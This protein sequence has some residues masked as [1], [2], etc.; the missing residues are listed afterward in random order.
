V[1]VLNAQ[2]ITAQNSNTPAAKATTTKSINALTPQAAMTHN[3]HTLSTP[4]L[5]NS[6]K[7]DYR[8]SNTAIVFDVDDVI[9]KRTIPIFSLAWQYKVEI[10]KA[11]FNFSLLKDVFTLIR[12]TAPVGVYISLFERKQP[13]LVPFARELITTRITDP[14][15][16]AIIKT[17]LSLGYELHIGT[18]E[19]ANEFLLH[20]ERFPIFSRFATYTFADYSTFPDVTQKPQLRYFERMK[21]RI[22]AYNKKTTNLIFIDDRTDNVQASKDTGY[23]GIVFTIPEALEAELVTMGIMPPISTMS[24]LLPL[25]AL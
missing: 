19:T 13:G 7:N 16:V 2:A 5:K 10:F 24:P 21:D 3:A 18:N 9:V 8:P 25:V 11:L 23:I 15:T 4:L 12:M 22:L 6:T 1:N 20:Q 17:L 14:K